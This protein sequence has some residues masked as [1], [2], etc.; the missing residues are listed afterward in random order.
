[1]LR[2]VVAAFGLM[3]ATGTSVTAQSQVVPPTSPIYSQPPLQVQPLLPPPAIP[4]APQTPVPDIE[5]PEPPMSPEQAWA[6]PPD[7]HRLWFNAD[8]LLWWVKPGPLPQPLVTS[9]SSLDAIP[10]A[11]GQLHTRVL[12]GQQNVD[13]GGASGL[14]ISG[15][16]WLDADH[17]WALDASGFLLQRD[18]NRNR[19]ISSSNSAVI[20]AQ[21][22]VNPLTG[23]GAYAASRLNQVAGI[24]DANTSTK[25]GGFEF[26]SIHN[27]MRADTLEI[28]LLAGFRFADLRESLTVQSDLQP[29]Q[30]NSVNFVGNSINVGDQLIINDRFA[31]TTHFYGPQIGIKLDWTYNRFGV[32][33]VGKLAMGVSHE[34]VSINGATALNPA[35]TDALVVVPGGILAQYTNSGWY[36]RDRFAVLP[37]ANL[38]L[39]Y[40]VM[41]WARLG[42]GYSFIYLSSAARP[43]L[44]VD[45][46]VNPSLV[47]SSA[48]YGVGAPG[49]G[50]NFVFRDSGYWAQGINFGITFRY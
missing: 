17:L 41:P 49:G 20:F 48:S 13:F 5:K 1:M 7:C 9:G 24:I 40:D 32:D 29:L 19:F 38:N 14:R 42:F 3:L 34:S 16:G 36:S 50:P 27:L 39:H 8:Y 35:G 31:T 4:S 6:T 12:L 23:E 45:R 15:G 18:D 25:F 47:P 30:A 44:L 26:N 33:F 46:N 2:I 43:G 11:L 21:P 37:E 10:G 28:D 22:I